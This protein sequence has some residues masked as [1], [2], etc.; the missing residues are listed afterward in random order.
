MPEPA[1]ERNAVMKRARRAFSYANVV[2]TLALFLALSG[3][4][5]YAAGKLGKNEVKSQNIAPKAVKSQ[6][7]ARNAVKNKNLAKN[8]VKN[9]NLAKNAVTGAKVRAGT[10]TR[11]QL[12]AGTL[13]GLQVAEVTSASVPGLATNPNEGE[14]PPS[15]GT[16]VPLSGT[17]AFTPAAGKSYE[18]LTELKGNPTDANGTEPEECYAWVTIFANGT[19]VTNVEIF[20]NAN[21]TPPFNVRTFDTSATA[22]GLLEAGQPITLTATSHGNPDCGSTAAALRAVVVELG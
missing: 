3:G 5:V 11:S 22:I 14:G 12:A 19:P 2:G 10:L 6:D 8:A 20:A 7:L 1:D 18:L 4:V 9:K 17:G 21:G 16:P 15:P 13:A